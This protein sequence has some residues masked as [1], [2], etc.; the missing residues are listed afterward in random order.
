MFTFAFVAFLMLNPP[1]NHHKDNVKE[2]TPT[3]F[4]LGIL[5]FQVMFKL[6]IHI[7]LIFINSVKWG[8]SFTLLHVNIQFSQHPFKTLSFPHCIFLAPLSKTNWRIHAF[9]SGLSIL[10]SWCICL[11][12]DNTTMWYC[13]IL[14][15]RIRNNRL[16]NQVI[17]LE[18]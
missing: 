10:F 1:K 2:L 15:L 12:L 17:E 6:F 16:R 9:I 4:L 18:I 5:W 7:E 8:C 11:F 13:L 3:I 14:W